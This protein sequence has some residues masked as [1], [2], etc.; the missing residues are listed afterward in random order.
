MKDAWSATSEPSGGSS[1]NKHFHWG[2]FFLW[3]AASFIVDAVL[4]IV[5]P[6]ITFAASGFNIHG[7]TSGSELSMYYLLNIIL[8]GYAAYK[9]RDAALGCFCGALLPVITMQGWFG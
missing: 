8:L 3:M 4:A 7:S 6:L 2:K 9:G 5:I 1:S